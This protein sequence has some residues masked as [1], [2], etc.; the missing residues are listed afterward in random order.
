MYPVL[1]AA[2]IFLYN[3]DIVPVGNDQK[4]HIELCRNIA[5]RVNNTKKKTFIIPE[6]RFLNEGARIMALDDPTRKMSKSAEN[7]YSR[8]SLLDDTNCW[9]FGSI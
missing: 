3:T 6:G 1:M 5:I 2:D 8:I 7:I 9:S 4:Q